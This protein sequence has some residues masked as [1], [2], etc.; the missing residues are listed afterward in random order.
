[1][2]M[3]HMKRDYRSYDAIVEGDIVDLGGI[4]R[5]VLAVTRDDRD[6]LRWVEVNRL[7]CGYAKNLYG[8]TVSYCTGPVHLY[9]T[10]LHSSPQY[11]FKGWYLRAAHPDTKENE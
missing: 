9:H 2:G 4:P 5:K 6:R 11:R 10:D 8:D 1:M 7:K 3:G